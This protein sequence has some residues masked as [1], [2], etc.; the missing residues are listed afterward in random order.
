MN[1]SRENYIFFLWKKIEQ[2]AEPHRKDQHWSLCAVQLSEI[3]VSLLTDGLKATT[4]AHFLLKAP[5]L[6]DLFL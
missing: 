4:Q 2:F 6:I 5:L 1:C 3:V